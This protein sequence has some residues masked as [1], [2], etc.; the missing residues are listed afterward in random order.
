MHRPLLLLLVGQ[1]LAAGSTAF[2][3]PSPRS[4]VPPTPTVCLHATSLEASPPPTLVTDEQGRTR[5]PFKKEGYSYWQW[6]GH[7]I[8]YVALGTLCLLA[9]D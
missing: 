5:L 1:L 7:N 2:L 3:L 8:H 6:Q 4:P 9:L